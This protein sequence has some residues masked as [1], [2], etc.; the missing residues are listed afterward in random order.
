MPPKNKFSNQNE[1]DNNDNEDIVEEQSPRDNSNELG[2]SY[3]SIDPQLNTH[4]VN[5]LDQNNNLMESVGY[6]YNG[7]M[8]ELGK[9][10]GESGPR[11]ARPDYKASNLS[12][13]PENQDASM[14]ASFMQDG[15]EYNQLQTNLQ[16][17]EEKYEKFKHDKLDEEQRIVTRQTAMNKKFDQ[18]IVKRKDDQELVEDDLNQ[19][20]ADGIDERLYKG[21][22]KTLLQKEKITELNGVIQAKNV[23]IANLIKNLRDTKNAQ[24]NK[25]TECDE[26]KRL[27]DQKNTEL[28]NI[29]NG[30][31]TNGRQADANIRA[32]KK[33]VVEQRRRYD[34]INRMD[35]YNFWN[36]GNDK[37]IALR[38][39]QQKR[40]NMQPRLQNNNNDIDSGNMYGGNQ[41]DMGN[42]HNGEGYRPQKPVGGDDV[43]E[44]PPSNL[45]LNN[46]DKLDFF[47]PG[48]NSGIGNSKGGKKFQIKKK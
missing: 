5:E 34:D 21:T 10:N 4:D 41:D 12:Q 20:V 16:K 24:L 26:Y 18:M 3:Q 28:Q 45:W 47:G 33:D 17:L 2:N 22:R 39:A 9:N 15:S 30:E 43:R 46:E 35:T 31:F 7:M 38:E 8:N 36:N 13:I 27:L 6:E 19:D 48:R 1:A 44:S 32:A 42:G 23:E 11:R 29:E 14:I 37:E 40:T 25:E